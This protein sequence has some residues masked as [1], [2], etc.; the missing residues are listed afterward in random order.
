LPD[1]EQIT[2]LV[3]AAQRGDEYAFA[4]LVRALQNIAVAYAASI[5]RDYH[6]AEDAAQEAFVEAYRELGNLR[7]PAAFQAWFRKILFKHC[8]RL[9]R[10]KR[11]PLTDL[12]SARTVAEPAPSPYEKL[13]QRE[14]QAALWQAIAALSEAERTVVLL[15]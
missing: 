15:Y 10:R 2:S 1:K 11:R 9:T 13:E 4:A 8:D 5:L 12:D 14:N 7:E 6:L 3:Q